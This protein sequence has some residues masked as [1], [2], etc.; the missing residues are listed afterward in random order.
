MKKVI[1]DGVEYVP[2]TPEVKEENRDRITG[3]YC[4]IYS[5]GFRRLRWARHIDIYPDPEHK[6][7]VELVERK[8]NEIIVSKDDVSRIIGLF[9]DGMCEV[10]CL[11]VLFKKDGV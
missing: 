5:N 1:I 3:A 9:A 11:K 7:C 2:V 6:E 10:D 8:E 4:H